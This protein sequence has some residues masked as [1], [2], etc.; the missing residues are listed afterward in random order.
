MMKRIKKI[1]EN[2]EYEEIKC[3]KFRTNGKKLSA[4]TKIL[5]IIGSIG[6]LGAII[7]GNASIEKIMNIDIATVIVGLATSSA[8]TMIGAIINHEYLDKNDNKCRIRKEQEYGELINIKEKQTSQENGINKVVG[9]MKRNKIISALGTLQ[10]LTVAGVALAL[11]YGH[12]MSNKT[13]EP[14]KFQNPYKT[15][16]THQKNTE[17]GE[18]K[19]IDEKPKI[20]ITKKI[21][22]HVNTPTKQ[23]NSVVSSVYSSVVSSVYSIEENKIS[24]TDNVYGIEINKLSVGNS[25][26]GI[27]VDTKEVK[28][29]LKEASNIFLNVLSTPKEAI[30]KYR[31]VGEYIKEYRAN[32]QL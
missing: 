30:E 3:G 16:I 2:A 22:K 25:V 21:Q 12:P 9:W 23:Y 19:V 20:E 18:E 27:D 5:E 15:A 8:I 10:T 1:I 13:V 28:G 11:A 31:T 6:F 24:V 14:E 32:G 4:K 17:V 26:Y 29:D 7:L